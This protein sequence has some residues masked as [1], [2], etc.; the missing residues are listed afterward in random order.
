[1]LTPV[2]MDNTRRSAL[3]QCPRKFYWRHIRNLQPQSG[4][5]ALR[6]GSAWHEAL[7]HFYISLQQGQSYSECLAAGSK[8]ATAFWEQETEKFNFY[9][10]YR[11]LENL[12]QAFVRYVDNY[13][14]DKDN[15]E[16][17]AIEKIFSIHPF[18]DPLLV[19][20]GKIDLIVKLAGQIWIMEHKTTSES[21]QSQQR[22]IQRDPQLLG[23]CFAS[24]HLPDFPP[25]EGIIINTLSIS[26][27]KSRTTGLYGQPRIDFSRMMQIFTEEDFSTWKENFLFAADLYKQCL[28]SNDWPPFLDSCYHYGSC[29]YTPLCEQ[30]RSLGST[31]TDGFVETEP[32]DVERS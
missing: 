21:T 27:T 2:K 31:N 24:K 15:Y 10:D 32:W 11:T 25:A 13:Y 7:E 28:Q 29:T 4:S 5:S 20:T 3:M 18:S 30:N 1:M 19:F 22:K 6:F 26:A 9:Q 16:I 14:T 12:L 23:Y 17:L 8:A